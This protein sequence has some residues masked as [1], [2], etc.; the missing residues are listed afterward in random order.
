MTEPDSPTLLEVRVIP[1]ARRDEVG[2]HRAGRLI[3]RTTAAPTDG[4]ANEAVR[5]LLARHLAVSV[6]DIEIVRGHRTRD[7]TV[8]VNR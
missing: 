4:A 6:R 5:R 8:R 7:K 3:I 2:G 1:R